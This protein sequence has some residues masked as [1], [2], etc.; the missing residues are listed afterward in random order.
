MKFL[1]ILLSLLFT[2]ALTVASPIGGGDPLGLNHLIA[3]L[4]RL[5][6][7]ADPA[8]ADPAPPP[9]TPVPAGFARCA[10]IGDKDVWSESCPGGPSC[11]KV[12]EFLSSRSVVIS[13]LI[14]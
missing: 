14:C 3:E 4:F 7:P 2:A 9:A 5:V 13:V 1:P 8:P 6:D 12:F 10:V 11:K